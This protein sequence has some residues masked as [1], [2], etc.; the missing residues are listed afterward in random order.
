MPNEAR[1]RIIPGV[2]VRVCIQARVCKP[3]C[4]CAVVRV[5]VSRSMR[6]L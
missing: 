6:V 5:C 4:A 3:K 2:V 1:M